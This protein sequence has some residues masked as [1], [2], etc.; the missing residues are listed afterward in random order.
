VRL[1]DWVLTSAGVGPL[2]ARVPGT[3]AGALRDAGLW[4]HD[5]PR[6]FDAAEWT[7]TTRFSAAPTG[8]AEEV[9]LRFDGIATV[10]EVELN[11][12][13]ILSSASMFEPHD[14]DVGALLA[15]D[16]ELVVRCAPLAPLLEERRRPRA[17]WR[18][19]V[20]ASQNLRF[21]RT[22]MLGRAPGFAPRPAPVGPWRPVML[23]R[24]RGLVVDAL[25]LRTTLDG[26]EGVLS[27]RAQ[28]RA[29][30]GELPRVVEVAVRGASAAE[31]EVG[32]DGGVVGT[33]RIPQVE[34]W[35][36]H[37]HGDPA[38][39]DVRLRVGDLDVPAGSVGF[40]TL[41]SAGDGLALRVNGCPV[42]ARGAVWTPVDPV[43]L[44]P[45]AEQVHA[46]VALAR[47][48]GMNMLRIPGTGLYE[49]E[50]FHAACDELGVL[51]WQDLLFAN[52]DY[53][54]EDDAFAATAEAE[55]R[56]VLARLASR[57][58]TAVVCGNSEVEQQATM[59]GLEPEVARSPF[60]YER[61]PE[62]IDAS[63]SDM[64][65]VPSA[66]SG[67]IDLPFRP[68]ATVANYY[69]V[70]AY[71]RPLADAR[72]AGV[73]FAAECLAFA[74]VPDTAGIDAPVPRDVGADWDFADVRDHYLRELFAVDP[75]ALRDIDPDRY[76][77]LSRAVTGE[78]MAAVAGE[79]RRAA[80]SCNGMLVLTL[81]DL[82][83]G[84]GWG[85]LDHD[86]APKVA[87]RYLR[88]AFAPLAVWLTDEGL[89]GI[90]VHVANDL[91]RGLAGRLRVA[92][93]R[94]RQLVVEE[95]ETPLALD[96]HTTVSHG[97]E[98][99]LGRFVDASYAY[100]FGPPAHDLIAA[101]L[102]GDQ[103]PIAQAFA[104]PVGPPLD[105]EPAEALGLDAV[106][107]ASSPS[108]LEIVVTS[109]RFAYCVRVHADGFVALDD[110]V[111]IEPGRARTITLT[112]RP[113]GGP[114][115]GG[116]LTAL[117]LAGRVPVRGG[118]P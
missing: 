77:E 108:R 40:R 114:W 105:R 38:L 62:L 68:A 111:S 23:E 15:A 118:A 7:F 46:A 31:L 35:W 50:A 87:W 75:V 6:D 47:D 22:T 48:A 9:I 117:N 58:S 10:A 100:R 39:Y 102:E 103:G 21:F 57:P 112:A 95:V 25:D 61:V 51:V 16:N 17:R 81:R 20:V 43:G 65:Y 32:S 19:R 29:L 85:V 113:G 80:S 78:V 107:A 101:T 115:T 41:E 89:Q 69:G 64:P 27:V 90:D 70:G 88:R 94:D 42:F 28:L 98:E 99:L 52:F 73:R 82:G 109:A 56:H 4:D 11:G 34:R 104:F 106:V 84:A 1:E 24:R 96:P 83:P 71:L 53:P 74:N 30:D 55:V 12:R 5:D 67:G 49:A 33:I 91:P 60:F 79:W 18:T 92:L 59:L 116:D 63:G 44:A 93:Y 97:V 110:A 2:P 72:L 54:F 13:P 86:G 45:S 76:L 66:P 37:T 8:G 3:A 26:D 14:V 36:P